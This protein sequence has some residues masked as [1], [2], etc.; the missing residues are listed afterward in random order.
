MF[1]AQAV[2][3]IKT[4]NC[5]FIFHGI[6]FGMLPILIPLYFVDFLE[7][8]IFDFGLMS[9]ISTFFS[10]LAS[11]YAGRLPEIHERVKPYILGSFLLSSLFLFALTKTS[12]L[13][14]FQILYILLGAANSIYGPSTRIFIAE[15]YQKAD[16]G[17]TFAVHNLVVGLSNTLGL[18]ICSLAV[19]NIGYG[20][21]LFICAPL[22]LAS[23]LVALAVINDPPIYV[24]RWLSRI[25]RPIDDVESFSYWF[26]STRSAGKIRL[27]P[28]VNMTLFGL[29]TSIFIL[30]TSSAFSS[31]PIFLSNTIFM[32]PSTIFAI[33]FGRS[34]IGSISYVFV[35]KL[36]G[37]GGGGS[38]VKVASIA[39]AV[40]VLLFIS[41][42]FSPLVGPIV[43]VL[44]LSALEVSWSL[45]SIGSSTVIVNYATEGSMGYY[46]ALSSVGSVVGALLSGA[47]PAI[48]GFNFLFILASALFLVGF[49]VF[50]RASS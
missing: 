10:I 2:I 23:F 12:N 48:F 26:G 37:E 38:A 29:G 33:Y 34:L 16:W 13:Y 17:R 8:S 36:S 49:L 30:A 50:S 32:A 42:S 39:R 35:G 47:I 46:D 20:T 22:V 7:G 9:A 14:L 19:S 1:Y 15:T 28:T 5:A 45:Y 3:S 31:L 44:L 24:E 40:L 41:V 4:W 25:S 21:L 18:A 43:I 11:I 6:A 27:T